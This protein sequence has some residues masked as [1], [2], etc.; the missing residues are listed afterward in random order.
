MLRL[1]V[2]SL[3][4][5]FHDGIN[6]VLALGDIHDCAVNPPDKGP[7]VGCPQARNHIFRNVLRQFFPK[8][9]IEGPG[10]LLGSVGCNE[11]LADGGKDLIRQLHA[12]QGQFKGRSLDG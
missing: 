9:L 2:K 3:V 8:S 6:H 12:S 10:N 4:E 5:G 11:G 1:E 7:F